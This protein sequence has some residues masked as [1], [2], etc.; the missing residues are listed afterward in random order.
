MTKELIKTELDDLLVRKNLTQR[1]IAYESGIP[2]STFNGYT[3]GAQAV[4]VQ[5]ATQIAEN[6]GDDLFCS[7]MANVYFGTIKA[8]DGKVTEVLTPTELDFLQDLETQ[9]REERRN[10]A[11]SLIIKAKLEPLSL[12]DRKDL[13]EYVMQ[14]LDE[15]VVELSIVFSILSILNMSVKQAFAERLPHWIAKKYMRG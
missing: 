12:E 15:I 11:K 7:Q 6:A 9:E 8:L 1:E 2:F 4:T 10:Q 5:K 13:Q 14:F 3:K